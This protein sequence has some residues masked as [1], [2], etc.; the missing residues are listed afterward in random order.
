MSPCNAQERKALCAAHLENA[1]LKTVI[2][3]K[4]AEIAQLMLQLNAVK[5][6][7]SGAES[8]RI[9]IEKLQKE[10]NIA[11]ETISHL[12]SKL[13]ESHPEVC[14]KSIDRKS[15][16]EQNQALSEE[17][18]QCQ[19]DLKIAKAT[20]EAS[21]IAAQSKDRRAI[22]QLQHEVDAL[23]LEVVQVQTE[24]DKLL[25]AR[26][27]EKE[28]NAR[29]C[30]VERL[31]NEVQR[32]RQNEADAARAAGRSLKRNFV[33]MA[34][35]LM[36]IL[37]LIQSKYGTAV[38]NLDLRIENLKSSVTGLGALRTMPCVVPAPTHDSERF[39]AQL[40]RGIKSIEQ[41]SQQYAN[42]RILQLKCN[43]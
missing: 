36:K 39:M 16:E 9:V 6:K 7:L 33:R 22:Q 42:S 14:A 8:N 34:S 24:A 32:L 13:K 17:L 29:Q 41:L 23:K 25:R 5:S 3:E 2:S 30:E 12:E 43:S 21:S 35:N 40:A 37:D 15:L 4:E 20:A 26:V 31:Q 1:Q 18:A 11:H 10:L 28:F 38:G 27:S 19:S